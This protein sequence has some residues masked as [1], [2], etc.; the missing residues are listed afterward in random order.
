MTPLRN[1]WIQSLHYFASSARTQEVFDNFSANS[2]AKGSV[3]LSVT[4]LFNVSCNLYFLFFLIFILIC[5]YFTYL[6][7]CYIRFFLSKIKIK[8]TFAYQAMLLV[9]KGRRSMTSPK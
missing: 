8:P 6:A 4:T 3:L 9:I 7:F 2:A 5:L 1:R